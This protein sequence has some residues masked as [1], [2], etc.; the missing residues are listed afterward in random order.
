MKA[1]V[2]GLCML[3]CA[4]V[5][6]GGL[7]EAAVP[8]KVDIVSDGFMIT[9]VF[10][11]AGGC[12]S[13]NKLFIKIDH[14]QYKTLY[15]T[16]LTAFVSKQKIVGYVHSCEPVNWYSAPSYTYNIVQGYGSLAITE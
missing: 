8:T 6:A 2:F 13:S 10:G 14:P 4:M 16:A 7:S 9:G 11:N 1:V 15:A 3:S 12:S 5:Y